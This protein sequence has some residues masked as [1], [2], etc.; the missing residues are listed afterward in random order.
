MSLVDTLK[1]SYYA[2]PVIDNPDVSQKQREAFP[3]YYGQ[4]ICQSSTRLL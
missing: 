2:N 3:E 1:G 4:N